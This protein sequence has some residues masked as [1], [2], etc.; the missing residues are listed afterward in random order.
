MRA[1]RQCHL[2][3]TLDMTQIEIEAALEVDTARS[4][5]FFS[6][7][8]ASST[9]SWQHALAHAERLQG[10]DADSRAQELRL[11]QERDPDLHAHAQSLLAPATRTNDSM[12]L[13]L[14]GGAPLHDSL[15][16]GIDLAGRQVGAY[17]LVRL[18]GEGGM[19][20]VWLAERTDGRFEGQV[21]IKLLG[22]ALHSDRLERFRREG[23]LLG[24][25][26]HPCIARLLDA[27]ALPGGQP[28]L[29]LEHV[30]GE[31]VDRWC[32]RRRLPVAARLS[33]FMQICAA[34]SHAHANLV[35]HRDLKPSNILVCDNG[36]PKLLDFGIAKLIEPET[37]GAEPTALTQPAGRAMTPEYAAPEQV[38]GA[39][40]TT[41]TD[42]YALG[43]LL[44][45]LLAGRRPYGGAPATA[46]EMAR[47]VLEADPLPLSQGEL[48]EAAQARGCT[49]ERLR[50]EL[51]GDLDT[52]VAKAL[53]K[54]PAERY[55]TVQS[56]ADELR[57]YLD[58]HPVLARPDTLV[59]RARKFIRRHRLPV[60]AAALATLAL[61]AG[62]GSALWQAELA[63]QQRAVAVSQSARAESALSQVQQ[64]S[65]LAHH[66][67]LR[68]EADA[69][70]AAQQAIVAGE[71]AA[72][73]QQ[74][75]READASAAAARR[76]TLLAIAERDRTR[77]VTEFLVDLFQTNSVYRDG[78]VA[79][80]QLTA[81]DLLDRGAAKLGIHASERTALQT[82]LLYTLGQLYAEIGEHA[83]A[84]TLLEDAVEQSR[85]MHGPRHAELARR[86]VHLGGLYLAQ[87]RF[88]RA[89]TALAEAQAVFDAIGDAGSVD[90]GLH[91]G[92]LAQLHLSH[93]AELALRHARRAVALLDAV[94]G[95]PRHAP[96]AR[97]VYTF[98][99]HAQTR[100]G[101]YVAA[102][103][104]HRRSLELA[105]Q[106]SGPDGLPTAAARAHLG[107]LLQMRG[108][109]REAETELRDS[110][111][112]T[113]KA[114][115]DDAVMIAQAE[116]RHG[117]VLHAMGER[118]RGRSLMAGA[119]S[120]FE[121]NFGADAATT[122]QAQQALARSLVAEGD[123]AGAQ[124]LLDLVQ[125]AVERQ[126]ALRVNLAGLLNQRARLLAD[127]GDAAA[128]R[129]SLERA[130]SLLRAAGSTRSFAALE[131]ERILAE[132]ELRAGRYDESLQRYRA[133]GQEAQPRG[134]MFATPQRLLLHEGRVALARGDAAFA[135][136]RFAAIKRTVLA[137]PD[138][139]LR[140]ELLASATQWL[141]RAY[142][143]QADP[144]RARPE[145]ELSLSLLRRWQSP[146]SLQLA[147]AQTHLAM[148]LLAL[149]ETAAAR[150]LA[151]Q[152]QAIH[153]RHARLS[154]EHRA[155]LR[156][157][158]AALSSRGSAG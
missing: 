19:G 116:L 61:A 135:A 117:R 24:R 9:A 40:I 107:E 10:L 127:A 67:A 91:H 85:R 33:L 128:A 76:Q 48:G 17:R 30:A 132:L 69:A 105:L 49:A 58:H 98:L 86:L 133:A 65:Q 71:R 13:G 6:M 68:A 118:E 101:D 54:D 35:V 126:P 5:P 55:L 153:D 52:V 75:R 152:A 21:A 119:V 64:Q 131:S 95:R 62:L 87:G 129:A 47:Q 111:R 63:R 74:A 70:R 16:E 31:R 1:V 59:Y 138:A 145:L 83:R 147:E 56:L 106:T 123:I 53:K 142:L 72:E 50:R 2:A 115:P 94:A 140:G 103:A 134:I 136:Q 18:L 156:A 143:A 46:V 73:A 141:G 36:V 39:A 4:S 130:L 37:A 97:L 11:L 122:L 77:E 27:G 99:G 120:V 25:L 139:E 102:E 3:S 42:V 22:A 155:P 57:R 158:Q 124:A 149:R 84:A 81:K 144:A 137:A 96:Q 60:S 100:L 114:N 45:W 8:D 32:D 109:P 79:A 146:A 23:Q 89:R 110:V 66:N 38:S 14:A 78:P 125:P 34:V 113:R 92:H 150:A 148:C 51:R 90:R 15:A 29:V 26:S 157:V 28:Y 41:A 82:Q 44:Y 121:S 80:R 88:D 112:G 104:A 151:A 7:N 108:K 93:D 43:V 20:Q 12:L 154:D